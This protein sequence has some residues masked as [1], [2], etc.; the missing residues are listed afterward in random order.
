MLKRVLFLVLPVTFMASTAHAGFT[1]VQRIENSAPLLRAG[2]SPLQ[3]KRLACW[4]SAEKHL[5]RQLKTASGLR[6]VSCLDGLK[7]QHLQTLARGLVANCVHDIKR[8]LNDED[9]LTADEF[10][11]VW[12]QSFSPMY[13]QWCLGERGRAQASVT[14]VN[15]ARVK[16]S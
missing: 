5:P 4:A 11:S 10:A 6:A 14:R 13:R 12:G 8:E 15:A 9:L 1:A 2:K 7:D 16:G 3:R